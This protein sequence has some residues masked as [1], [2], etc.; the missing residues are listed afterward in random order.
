RLAE[1]VQRRVAI[2]D[3]FAA[4]QNQRVEDLAQGRR[5]GDGARHGGDAVRDF[6]NQPAEIRVSGKIVVVGDPAAPDTLALVRAAQ[7]GAPPTHTLNR[8]AP[9]TD[10]PSGHPAHGMG[11]IDGRPTAYVCVG[12]ACGL[13]STDAGAL[14]DELARL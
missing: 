4:G 5:D 2:R 10:L 6:G 8:I 12:A 13:P 14:R 7:N 11:Q 9:G 1:I 3:R